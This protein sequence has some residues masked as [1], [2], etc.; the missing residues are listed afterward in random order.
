M[1]KHNKEAPMMRNLIVSTAIGVISFIGNDHP[2]NFWRNSGQK[3]RPFCLRK[4][5]SYDKKI[6]K[7]AITIFGGW[8]LLGYG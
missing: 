3:C 8:L 2:I 5:L 1:E 4:I 7:T 6:T